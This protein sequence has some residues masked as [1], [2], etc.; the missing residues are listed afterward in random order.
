MTVPC[1]TLALVIKQNSRIVMPGRSMTL[2]PTLLK[3][4]G[5]APT[6]SVPVARTLS[7]WYA[8]PSSLTQPVWLSAKGVELVPSPWK[9]AFEN[10][11]SPP[12]PDVDEVGFACTRPGVRH[13]L[14]AQELARR[15]V[16]PQREDPVHPRDR[17]WRARYRLRDRD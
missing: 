10:G 3:T 11:W 1:P 5:V 14:M 7:V 9:R 17:G 2:R 15:R 16:H 8:A 12:A 4:L 13:D 6:S